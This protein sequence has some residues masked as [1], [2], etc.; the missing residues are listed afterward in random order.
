MKN[1]QKAKFFLGSKKDNPTVNVRQKSQPQ[2]KFCVAVTSAKVAL[3]F[4]KN[5]DKGKRIQKSCINF[6][7]FSDKTTFV[8]FK[9]SPEIRGYKFTENK[10]PGRQLQYNSRVFIFEIFDTIIIFCHHGLVLI[11]NYRTRKN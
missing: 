2:K 3:K 11:L 8:Y 5:L 4:G 1:R 6:P 7:G 9:K 10:Q